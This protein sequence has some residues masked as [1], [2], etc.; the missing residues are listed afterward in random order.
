[1]LASIGVRSVFPLTNQDLD[2]QN[3]LVVATVVVHKNRVLPARSSGATGVAHLRW[4]V[5]VSPRACG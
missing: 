4:S 2:I 5:L 1:M 3:H